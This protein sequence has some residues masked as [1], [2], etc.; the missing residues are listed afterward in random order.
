MDKVSLD[1]MYWGYMD[2][3]SLDKMYWGYMDKVSLDKMYVFKVSPKKYHQTKCHLVYVS[4]FSLVHSCQY[5]FS[6]Y[7]GANLPLLFV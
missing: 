1:K 3:V 6:K 2:K 7:K 5:F 4:M